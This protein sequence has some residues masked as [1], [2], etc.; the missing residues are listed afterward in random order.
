MIHHEFL[1]EYNLDCKWICELQNG[2]VCDEP[3]EESIMMPVVRPEVQ[4]L[5]SILVNIDVNPTS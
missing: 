4:E 5:H 1:I 3:P 2:N